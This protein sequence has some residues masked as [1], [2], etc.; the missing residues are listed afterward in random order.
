[1]TTGLGAAIPWL[2]HGTPQYLSSFDTNIGMFVKEY[3]QSV[4]LPS[5]PDVSCW[6]MMLHGAQSTLQLHIYKELLVD[7]ASQYNAG[8]CDQCRIIGM[9]RI[10]PCYH[11]L[12]QQLHHWHGWK[13]IGFPCCAGWQNHPVSRH[14]YHFIVPVH[15]GVFVTAHTAE[16]S[17]ALPVPE[18]RTHSTVL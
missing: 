8:I 4:G 9:R 12:L 3:A 5:L 11:G 17:A 6:V 1:M 16:E 14:K 15:E 13:A 7:G 10:M 18:G 2:S